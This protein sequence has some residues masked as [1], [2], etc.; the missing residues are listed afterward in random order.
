MA[1][2]IR[3]GVSYKRHQFRKGVCRKC[4]AVQKP[5]SAKAIARKDKKAEAVHV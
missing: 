5:K 1:R 4:E 2:C 3:S